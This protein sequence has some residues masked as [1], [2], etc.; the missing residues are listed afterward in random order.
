M[1]TVLVVTLLLF[2]ASLSLGPARADDCRAVAATIR[3]CSYT[4]NASD[5]HEHGASVQETSTGVYAQVD[6]GSY[7]ISNFGSGNYTQVWIGQGRGGFTNNGSLAY[8]TTQSHVERPY[9]HG[10]AQ[11]ASFGVGNSTSFASAGARHADGQGFA[12][13][14][15]DAIDP[16]TEFLVR[17][18]A[19]PRGAD[20]ILCVWAPAAV[21][22]PLAA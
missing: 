16:A 6:H 11:E 20:V 2:L 12:A 22:V 17:V 3:E 14:S 18:H 21:C 13:G 8:V 4:W 10:P 15:F 5:G 9:S 7:N 1:R 19:D